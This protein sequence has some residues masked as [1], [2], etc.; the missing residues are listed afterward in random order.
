MRKFF[1]PA[2]NIKDTSAFITGSDVHHIT[3]VLRKTPG[4]IIM[5]TDGRGGELKVRI[6]EILPGSVK[7]EILE[8]S[9]SEGRKIFVRLYQAIPRGVKFDWVVEKSCEI[10][11]NELV[12]LITERTVAK[13]SEERG[14]KKIARWERI[15][16]ET[17]KQTGRSS[18]MAIYKAVSVEK[19]PEMMLKD[20]LKILFWEL[21]EENNLRDILS[22]G[23]SQRVELV[24]GPEGGFSC[25]EAEN[26]INSGFQSTSLGKMVL[27]TDTAA[28]SAL[29]N[30]YFALE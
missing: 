3:H 23:R 29:S 15:S 7:L 27:K 25:G 22:G 4:D 5:A 14:L 2:E 12:P 30:I 17:M 10:G 6:K 11:V 9:P 28:L 13:L 21:E 16:L 8:M 19:I 1:I 18:P 24:I 26:L 20:S